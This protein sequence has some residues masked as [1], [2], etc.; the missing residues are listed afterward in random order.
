[1]SPRFRQFARKTQLFSQ[2]GNA[3]FES[4]GSLIGRIVTIGR[5]ASILAEH[6]DPDGTD[7]IIRSL[8]LVKNAKSIAVEKDGENWKVFEE[9][10]KSDYV[11]A[12]T[13][14]D[15]AQIIRD[16]DATKGALL[17]VG[18]T[19]TGKSSLARRVIQTLYP[20]GR[21]V[22]ITASLF[23]SSR[24]SGTVDAI[25]RVWKPD[26][27]I[28]DDANLAL[29]SGSARFRSGDETNTILQTMS[30]LRGKCFTVLTQMEDDTF[31]HSLMNQP[32]PGALYYPGMRPGRVDYVL[33]LHV[34]DEER[35]KQILTH[36]LGEDAPEEL[37]KLT[38]GLTC[39]YLRA[40]AIAYMRS[41][42][43]R[44]I[45]A[46]LVLSCPRT[47]TRSEVHIIYRVREEVDRIRKH[48]GLSEPENRDEEYDTFFEEP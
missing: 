5:I 28:I 37:V 13:P 32:R 36:Y 16:L 2:L 12:P 11:G 40:S 22:R 26:A 48:L 20:N 10:Y 18:A 47:L 45:V 23:A 9:D 21:T 6:L 8:A 30:F 43:W 41:P 44:R 17:I 39:A 38:E 15:V 24:A 27:L 14:E 35:R 4:Q 1:M 31:R 7:V 33:A 19:G 29:H 34:P 42:H 3:L 25:L 46:S